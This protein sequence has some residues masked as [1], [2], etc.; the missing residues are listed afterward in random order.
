MVKAWNKTFAVTSVVKKKQDIV[1]GLPASL[2]LFDELCLWKRFFR[3]LSISTI[4]SEQYLNPVEQGKCFAGAEF[5]AP[6]SA[7]FGH[8]AYLADKVDYIF[9]PIMLEARPCNGGGRKSFCY[10]TQYSSGLAATVKDFRIEEKCLLPLIYHSNSSGQTK[11]QLWRCLSP[12]LGGKATRSMLY[13]AYDE[14][15]QY[16][17]A[18]KGQLIQLFEKEFDADSNISV[19]LIGRPYVVLSPAMNKGIPDI[20]SKMGVKTFY[21]D[22]IPADTTDL[23]DIDSLLDRIPW[24]YAANILSAA[25]IAAKRMVSFLF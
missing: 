18:Q 8:T 23:G 5:C 21:Q 1:I 17:L 4:S 19:V 3:N 14:A 16:F 24:Q 6:I 22:M 2:H 12:I 7:M 13:R 25:K 15:E 20:L 10:Y 9:L 11:K